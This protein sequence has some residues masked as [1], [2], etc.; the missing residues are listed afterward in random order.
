MMQKD[1]NNKNKIDLSPQEIQ[2]L[3]EE[4]NKKIITNLT[5]ELELYKNYCVN[6]LKII[7]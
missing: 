2:N 7:N 5:I 3:K 1:H 6:L 4:K